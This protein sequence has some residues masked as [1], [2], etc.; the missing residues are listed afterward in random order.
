MLARLQEH[1]RR[2]KESE[3]G[4]Q[5]NSLGWTIWEEWRTRCS[6][7]WQVQAMGKGCEPAVERN[8]ALEV[9]LIVGSSVRPF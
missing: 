5:R 7:S 4:G 1:R 8:G 9:S 6:E 2:S 3:A